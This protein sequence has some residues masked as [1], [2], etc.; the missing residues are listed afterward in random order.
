MR[1]PP[2][3]S[4]LLP[5]LP[6]LAILFSCGAKPPAAPAG[7]PGEAKSAEVKLFTPDPAT[8]GTVRGEVL[9]SG[10]R[11][12]APPIDL[13]S[14]ADCAKLHPKGQIPDESVV[15]GTGGTLRHSFVY[16]KAEFPDQRFAMPAE[17]AVIDQR[18]CQFGPRVLGLRTG[19]PLRVTN[20][21]GV[22]HN[23]H[24][25]P[26]RNREWNQSQAPEDGPLTRKFVRSEVMIRVKCNVH[27]WMRAWIGVLDHP[28]F[29]VTGEDGKFQ[30]PNLPP[31]EYTLVVWHETFGTKEQ[32]VKISPSATVESNFNFQGE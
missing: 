4:A 22:T 2:T 31:G 11:P 19:Q 20:S 26:Q 8:V 10:K 9:F 21:D 6:L 13:S 1:I 18:G 3:F 25:E 12:V 16:I 24:P 7:A 28:Y 27:R 32:K 30:I 15:T 29:A 17:P 5:L 23:I 14:D